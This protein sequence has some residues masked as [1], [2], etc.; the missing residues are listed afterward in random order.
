M[1]SSITVMRRIS[2]SMQTTQQLLLPRKQGMG[3]AFAW[4][5]NN[6]GFSGSGVVPTC[7]LATSDLALTTTRSTLDA[8]QQ[9]LSSSQ[10]WKRLVQGLGLVVVGGA[11]LISYETNQR[12]TSVSCEG[13]TMN[14]A[15]NTEESSPPAD[16]DDEDEEGEDP[17]ANLPEEDEPTE[18]SMCNTFRKGPCRPF[19]RKLERCFKDHEKEENG[20]VKCMRYF[21]PHQQCIMKFT[22]LYQLVS[23]EMKQDLVRDAELSM[24]ENER[25]TWKPVV[26]WSLWKQFTAEAGISFR[27]TIR[28]KDAKSGELLPLWQRLPENKEPVLLSLTSQLPKVEEESGLLLKIA[29]A[30]D[31]D[32]F[33]LGLSYN[34]EYGALVELAQSKDSSSSEKETKDS[35]VKPD[36]AAGDAVPPEKDEST[37][38]EFNFH[39]LPGETKTVTICGLYAENPVNASPDKEILDALL[40]KNKPYNLRKIAL[41]KS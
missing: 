1:M 18:C 13:I 30:V 19:W 31:Q 35:D 40:Y 34:K 2:R 15:K 27:E 6:C 10:E 14:E 36:D 9:Q 28:S 16:D 7:A 3:G 32:G 24:S 17:Y 29:Y 25:R 26:D 22:N 8:H 4:Q 12:T 11:S 23:L 38:F 33:V 5:H 37:T 21:K 20:A 41:K 39:V